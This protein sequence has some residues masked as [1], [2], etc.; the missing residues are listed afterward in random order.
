MSNFTKIRPLGA[1]LLHADG[2]TG[3]SYKSLSTVLR[4][5]LKTKT[6]C[7]SFRELYFKLS[8]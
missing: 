7:S 4:R 3:R 2:Q 8:Y 5:R 6:E 1:E